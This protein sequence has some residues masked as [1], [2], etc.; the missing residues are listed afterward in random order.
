LPGALNY[1]IVAKALDGN[2]F[3]QDFDT[4]DESESAKN[5]YAPGAI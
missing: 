1:H 2:S 3:S 5:Q 4:P